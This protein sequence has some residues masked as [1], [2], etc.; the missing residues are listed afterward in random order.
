MLDEIRRRRCGNCNVSVSG[1]ASSSQQHKRHVIAGNRLFKVR[2][3][4]SA[5][6]FLFDEASKLPSKSNLGLL[7]H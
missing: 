4:A 5:T 3:S 7:K 1:L 2:W 6:A